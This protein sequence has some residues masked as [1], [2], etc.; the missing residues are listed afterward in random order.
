M[1][2]NKF[3]M[4]FRNDDLKMKD[5]ELNKENKNTEFQ[6]FLPDSIP[7]KLFVLN[8]IKIIYSLKD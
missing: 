3:E 6:L 5:L 1:K 2:K 4:D 8:L 7:K